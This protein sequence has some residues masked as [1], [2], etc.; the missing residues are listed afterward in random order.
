MTPRSATIRLRVPRGRAY[1]G[2][3]RD[4]SALQTMTVE[5]YFRFQEGSSI[6]YEY[7]AGELY[8]MSGA[9]ARH[10]SRWIP[11]VKNVC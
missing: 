5:E 1:R 9:T 4:P 7:V 6:K 11:T 2:N 3:M 10:N 8:A